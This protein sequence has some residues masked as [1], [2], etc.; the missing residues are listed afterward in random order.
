MMLENS[1]L[2]LKLKK[3]HEKVFEALTNLDKS[4]QYHE[5]MSVREMELKKENEKLWDITGQLS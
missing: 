1:E 2:S 4:K 5:K 3:K